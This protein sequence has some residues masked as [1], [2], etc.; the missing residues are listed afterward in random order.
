MTISNCRFAFSGGN[1]YAK[2]VY[3]EFKGDV[4][5]KVTGS[6]FFC[7]FDGTAPYMMCI[8][9]TGNA[10]RTPRVSIRGSTGL[11]P[12]RPSNNRTAPW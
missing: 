4:N 6:E 10:T 8:H 1:S 2:A 11:D 5:A 7:N 9:N 3:L 12:A